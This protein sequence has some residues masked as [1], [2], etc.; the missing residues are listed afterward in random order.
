VC[1]VGFETLLSRIGVGERWESN[2]LFVPR[3]ALLELELSHG[4]CHLV[5]L[6][7]LRSGIMTPFTTLLSTFGEPYK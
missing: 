1:T 5:V 2:R 7:C 4:I 3:D 6:R